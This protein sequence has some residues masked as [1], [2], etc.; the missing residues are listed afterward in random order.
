MTLASQVLAALA[1]M[2]PALLMLAVQHRETKRLGPPPAE[3]LMEIAYREG[4]QCCTAIYGLWGGCPD[5]C[6]YPEGHYGECEA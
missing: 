6:V 2:L 3:T 4:R 5:R 1:T